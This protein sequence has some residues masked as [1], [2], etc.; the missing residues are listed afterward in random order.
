MKLKLLLAFGLVYAIGCSGEQ[1]DDL[2]FDE[3]SDEDYEEDSEDEANLVDVE[4]L[5]A[6]DVG[7]SAEAEEPAPT[8]MPKTPIKVTTQS[9]PKPVAAKGAP[10]AVL[11]AGDAKEFMWV[12]VDR[13][14]VKPS[15]NNDKTV[16]YVSYGQKV[17]VL[18][19]VHGWVR[20]GEDKFVRIDDLTDRKQY[21]EKKSKIKWVKTP[22]L[23]IR[24]EPNRFSK[25]VGRLTKGEQVLVEKKSR[26]TWVKIGEGQYVNGKYLVNSPTKVDWAH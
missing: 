20:V 3:V 14:P 12:F 6:T 7:A 26:D 25:V 8:Q 5:M 19:K 2:I 13:A 9:K 4:A 15:P 21:Q 11:P 23:N 17:P 16:G 1:Q 18:D 22:D 24:S 10:N